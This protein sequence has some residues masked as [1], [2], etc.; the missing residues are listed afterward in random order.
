MGYAHRFLYPYGQV[1]WLTLFAPMVVMGGVLVRERVRSVL[2]RRVWV[3]VFVAAV[4]ALSGWTVWRMGRQAYERG[5]FAIIETN[6]L[7]SDGYR[8]AGRVLDEAASRTGRQLTLFHHNMGELMYFAPRWDSIDPVGLVDRYVSRHGFDV[9]YVFGR[10]PELFLL[11]SME[12][13]RITPYGA[14]LFPDIS[15]SLY[16][17]PRMEG[18][19]YLGYYPDLVFGRDGRMHVLASRAWLGEAGWAEGFLRREMDLVEPVSG[20]P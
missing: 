2:A 15:E 3:A 7:D 20:R 17:D 11:P 10:K 13:E 6:A 12:R 18:Y 5:D 14:E 19:E 8:R 1:L 4:V 16:R 9:D